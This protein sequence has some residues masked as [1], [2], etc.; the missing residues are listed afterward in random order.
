MVLRRI[1][2]DFDGVWCTI[3]YIWGDDMKRDRASKRFTVV[4]FILTAAM[5]LFA[6]IHSCFPADLS[7][8]ESEGV[9]QI[10]YRFFALFGA[11]QALTEQLVRKLA[12]FSEFAAI[13]GLLLSC[14]YC[15]DRR[16]PV[17]YAP[18]ML[19]AALSAA[20]IDET[21]QLFVEGRAGMIADVWID[22]GGAVCGMLVMW[23]IYALYT[24]RRRKRNEG[25]DGTGK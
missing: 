1:F 21:I 5:V 16:R 2:I 3:E 12:H 9:F 17:R 25:N 10:I 4:I 6:W 23:G 13:G 14:A 24:R 15:F 20:L 22:L 11:G 7:S 18:Q 19:L 8:R